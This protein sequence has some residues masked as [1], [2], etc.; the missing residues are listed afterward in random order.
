MKLPTI[1]KY[2]ELGDMFPTGYRAAWPDA[3]RCRDVCYPIGLHWILMLLRWLYHASYWKRWNELDALRVK[4]AS[5]DR[6]L[7]RITRQY[8][9]LARKYELQKQKCVCNPIGASHDFELRCLLE[10]I[11][12]VLFVV[13]GAWDDGLVDDLSCPI[14]VTSTREEAA[15]FVK[16]SAKDMRVS[17][18]QAKGQLARLI[19][20]S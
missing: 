16:D 12:D 2:R 13:T 8:Y 6:S 18:V 1:R 17:A 3:E 11:P 5:R 14:A 7:E 4:V 15:K 19:C 10:G 9:D 20:R